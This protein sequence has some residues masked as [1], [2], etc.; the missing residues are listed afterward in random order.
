MKHLRQYTD[1]HN[2]LPE[3]QSPTLKVVHFQLTED[4]VRTEKMYNFRQYWTVMG[5]RANFTY[6]KLVLNGNLWMSD[7]PMERNTNLDFLMY[8]NGD[9]LIFGLGIGLIVYPLLNDESIKSITV[10]END[11]AVID[12]I[13]P[14]LK[15][16]DALNKLIVLEGDAFTY[17]K[18]LPLVR[19]FDT[20]YFDIWVDIC[21][22]NYDS[23]KL[24]ERTY[25][26]FLNKSNPNKWMNSWMNPYYKKEKA[27]ERREQANN[28]W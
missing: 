21:L 9:V 11:K 19:K 20:I 22:D 17:N 7:T 27:K 25:R 1:V 2:F 5:L 18:H 6:T 4:Q 10:I 8:A 14:F 15:K 13:Y 3:L 24:L 26:R 23:Q 28:W 12:L 16:H